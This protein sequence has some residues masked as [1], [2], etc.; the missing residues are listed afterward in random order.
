MGDGFSKNQ[1][2]SLLFSGG[3]LWQLPLAAF[4]ISSKSQRRSHHIKLLS[5]RDSSLFS[6]ELS[7]PYCLLFLSV[8]LKTTVSWVLHP[9]AALPALA[10]RSRYVSALCPSKI[11]S[12]PQFTRVPPPPQLQISVWGPALFPLVLVF[13]SVP[14]PWHRRLWC[15]DS[16]GSRRL[17]PLSIYLLISAR[18]I[19][20]R[21]CS[22]LHTSKPTTRDILFL[23]SQRY[24]LTSQADFRSVQIH[25]Q[26][27][28]GDQLK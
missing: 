28:S 15:P 22:P 16:T 24:L 6:S 21:S 13:E 9:T 12:C 1:F 20:G 3:F 17:P 5:Q 18:R 11:T 23:E 14:S 27:D 2:W 7:K 8:L 26:L 19:T 10:S 4:C 25:I